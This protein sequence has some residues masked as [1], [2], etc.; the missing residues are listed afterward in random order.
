[1]IV[2][3]NLDHQMQFLFL[4]ALVFCLYLEFPC[5][6]R[7]FTGLLSPWKGVLL[8]GPPG[9]GKVSKLSYLFPNLGALPPTNGFYSKNLISHIKLEDQ[10]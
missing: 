10:D 1:M 2:V 4:T 6:F 8:F 3:E 5:L 9:T 7:Y